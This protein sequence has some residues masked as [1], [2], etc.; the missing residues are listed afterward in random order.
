MDSKK[1]RKNV[2]KKIEDKKVK[3]ILEPPT[4][5]PK[6]APVQKALETISADH[7]QTSAVTHKDGKLLGTVTKDGMN[8]GVGGLG[9]DPAGTPVEPQVDKDGA[10]C[11]E[12]QTLGE[13]ERLM[14]EKQAEEIPVVKKDK[15]VIG[16]TTLAK[17]EEEK[18]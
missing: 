1:S 6:D 7:V 15:V 18:Q 3:E 2:R 9:H 4:V 14:R 13:A 17:I 12:D 10:F 16:K 8:R 11:F 5:V